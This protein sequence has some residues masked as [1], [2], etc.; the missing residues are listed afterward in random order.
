LL[1]EGSLISL[2]L[3]NPLFK[4]YPHRVQRNVIWALEAIFVEEKA[5]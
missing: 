1:N 2:K 3:E 5:V 4:A